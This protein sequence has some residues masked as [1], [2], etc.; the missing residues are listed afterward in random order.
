M[1]C[2]APV[3][4]SMYTKVWRIYFLCS[5]EIQISTQNGKFYPDLSHWSAKEM[6]IEKYGL[7][8]N[9]EQ[10]WN[11]TYNRVEIVSL[12]TFVGVPL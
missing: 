3:F 11:L 1:F 8:T 2:F 10:K 12:S 6:S 5:L 7:L 4:R 9:S